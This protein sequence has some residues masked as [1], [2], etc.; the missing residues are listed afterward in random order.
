MKVNHENGL[1][2]RR[3]LRSVAIGA[4]VGAIAT[5]VVLSIMAAGMAAGVF[6]SRAVNLLAIVAAVFGSLIG[7]LISARMAGEKGLLYGLGAALLLFALTALVGFSL[8]AEARGLH[9]ALKA[10]LMLIAGAVGGVIGVN[11][12]RRR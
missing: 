12:R 2:A 6:P 7:G 4:A 5:V 10:V 8:F 1:L 3:I 9:P 11:L